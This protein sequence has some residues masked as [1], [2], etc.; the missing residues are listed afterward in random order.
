[1]TG[2][3]KGLLQTNA[4]DVMRLR[5]DSFFESLLQAAQHAGIISEDE[6]MRIQLECIHLLADKTK[7]YASGSYSFLIND[8][9]NIMKSN[10]YTIGLYLKSFSNPYSAIESIKDTPISELY[11]LGQKRIKTKLNVSRHLYL[12]IIETMIDTGY[13]YYTFTLTKQIK[14]FFD[15]YTDFFLWYSAHELPDNIIFSYPVC[16]PGY[17]GEQQELFAASL[18]SDF[19]GI[20]YVQRYLQAI[21]YENMFCKSFSS[22]AIQRVLLNYHADYNSI[23]FNIFEKVLIAAIGCAM[24]GEK[25]KD[26]YIS[27]D[28]L[29]MALAN[30]SEEETKLMLTNAY[31]KLIDEIGIKNVHVQEYVRKWLGV[32]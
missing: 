2:Q 20:E 29:E 15:L 27:K 13:D 31:Y 9:E 4:I 25:S 30:K 28:R 1:M 6:I 5:Q 18:I 26:L 14:Q 12:N 32:V 8:A 11:I 10:L 19:V 17:I 16:D 22:E 23:L 21:Y 7:K 3:N 24:A